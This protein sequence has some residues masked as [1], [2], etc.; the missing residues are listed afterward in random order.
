M[1]AAVG[2][3]EGGMG[4]REA[5]RLYNIPYETLRQRANHT[6]SIDCRPGP[7]TVLTDEEEQLALFCVQMADMGFGL[8]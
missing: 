2:M 8:S 1:T 7:S 4:I 6:V 3:V 5:A